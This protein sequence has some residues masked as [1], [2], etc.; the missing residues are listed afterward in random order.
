MHLV[1]TLTEQQVKQ[2]FEFCVSKLESANYQHLYCILFCILYLASFQCWQGRIYVVCNML[3]KPQ[4]TLGW[5]VRYVTRSKTTLKTYCRNSATHHWNLCIIKT[6]SIFFWLC[7]FDS[8]RLYALSIFCPT[9]CD[10]IPLWFKSVRHRTVTMLE[11]NDKSFKSLRCKW[12][13]TQLV[14]QVVEISAISNTCRFNLHDIMH[15]IW[16]SLSYFQ[17]GMHK[18]LG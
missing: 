16:I 12:Q 4:G 6:L 18:T 5:F 13:I 11:D 15:V 10:I 17:Q 9:L 8:M 1:E 3:Q 2:D 7:D 14:R